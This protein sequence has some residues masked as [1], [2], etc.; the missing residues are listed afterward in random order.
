MPQNT[1]VI[2]IE[3][4]LAII[5]LGQSQTRDVGVVGVHLE[6][7]R[8]SSIAD[9][10]RNPAELFVTSTLYSVLFHEIQE[11]TLS[12]EACGIGHNRCP[13]TFAF[14]VILLV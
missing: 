2:V 10:I 4:L 9:M 3:T 14:F 1:I 11:R 8:L 12:L 6:N 7:H 5:D 13:T